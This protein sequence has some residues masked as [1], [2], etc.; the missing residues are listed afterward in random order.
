MEMLNAV[1]VP[2]SRP[3]FTSSNC[4]HAVR[5]DAKYRLTV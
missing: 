2:G 5:T 3:L 1:Y 4:G